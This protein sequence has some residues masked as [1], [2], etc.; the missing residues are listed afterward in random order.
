MKSK[1]IK[2][3]K[4]LLRQVGVIVTV[5]FILIIVTAGSLIY[6]SCK[7]L[8]LEAKND[9]IDRDLR[10]IR[11][12]LS[13][14]SAIDWMLEY[15]KQ[16]PEDILIDASE[17]E[18]DIIKQ[19]LGRYQ[20]SDITHQMIENAPDEM[21]LAAAKFFFMSLAVDLM[22]E[23]T[24]FEYDRIAC[25]DISDED[26][27]FVYYADNDNGEDMVLEQSDIKLSEHPALKKLTSGSFSGDTVY[28]EYHSSEDGGSYYIGY[29][30]IIVDGEICCVIC[31]SYDW[32]EFQ[33]KLGFY[34]LLINVVG[35]LIM[36]VSAGLLLWFLH[37]SAIR[38]LKKIQKGVRNYMNDQ[39]SEKIIRQMETIRTTNELGVLSDDI[40]ELAQSIDR[41]TA[42]NIRLASEQERVAAELG[43]AAKIQ[44]DMLPKAFPDRREADL[45]ASMTPAKEIGG[46]FYDFF[47]IDDHRLGMVIADVSGKGVPA[48]LFMMMSMIV[49]RN[50]ARAG[51]SPSEVLSMANRIICE[52]N[53]DNMFV[54]VWFGV[55]DLDTGHIVAGN[56][57]HEFPI[58][59][60][61]D[62]SFE[63]FKDKHS[64]VLGG[65]AGMKYKEYEFDLEKGGAL[66]LYTDGVSEATDA[67]EQLFGTERMLCTLNALPDSSPEKLIGG[68]RRAIDAFVGE[69]PQFDDMTMLCIRYN[70]KDQ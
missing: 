29:T 50:Y 52:N 16:H 32:T 44:S 2:R 23:K 59:G 30:P 1:K 43:L 41:Y 15:C 46:D 22:I 38:P 4:K 26:F 45:Y 9:M 57:G 6:V 18:S 10:R 70:G 13:G 24:Q 34:L 37:R 61:P 8:Y 69:A 65:M 31:I 7:S 19:L 51:K 28:E 42:E 66:F 14:L 63:L 11:E 5:I 12:N 33:G 17:E 36:I 48:A 67:S 68:I 25:M 21:Q 40:C 49:V 35:L 58:I 3:N 60:K 39:D 55:L 20:N 47:M 62:G 53:T 27:G 54:T 64:F 56:A